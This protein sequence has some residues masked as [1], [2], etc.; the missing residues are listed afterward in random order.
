M[1]VL[2]VRADDTASE[3]GAYTADLRVSGGVGKGSGK[4][5][6][7]TADR[8]RQEHIL[9]SGNLIEIRMHWF[10]ASRQNMLVTQKCPKIDPELD[11][12]SGFSIIIQ[13]Y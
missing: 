3:Q 12:S 7:V 10:C 11:Q 2:A 9:S 5:F 1:A 4:C 6:E 13:I 8:D